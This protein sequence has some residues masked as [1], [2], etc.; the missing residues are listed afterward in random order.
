MRLAL[1]KRPRYANG[2]ATRTRSWDRDIGSINAIALY[3]RFPIPD[4]R[5]PTPDSRFLIPDSRLPIP[6]SRTRCKKPTPVSHTSHP[7]NISG[8]PF[9]ANPHPTILIFDRILFLNIRSKPQIGSKGITKGKLAYPHLL[10]T[11]NRH[12]TLSEDT[13]LATRVGEAASFIGPEIQAIPA[14]KMKEF[15]KSPHLKPYKFN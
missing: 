1:A 2:H 9:Q 3:S 11:A 7:L 13:F 4:S 6:D 14:K 10:T 12:K 15:M 5:L 8:H